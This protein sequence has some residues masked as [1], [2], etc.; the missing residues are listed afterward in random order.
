M[1]RSLTPRFQPRL[2]ALEERC[3]PSAA[4]RFLAP[5]ETDCVTAPLPAA[6]PPAFVPTAHLPANHAAGHSKSDVHAVPFKITGGGTAPLGLPVFPGGMAP[7]NATGTA[8]HLGK[9]TGDE[10]S[11]ELL[12]LD[13]ATL[14]GTFR[15]SFVFVAANGDRLAFDYGAD[16]DQPGTF[17]LT[18]TADGKVVAVFVAEFTPV[19]EESTGRFAKVTGGSFTM[20]ATS[21]A[22]ALTPN[23]Q[24]F[25]PPFAYTWAGEGSL[26]FGRG[27]K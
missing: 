16:P 2:E 13:P 18:P 9:Y 17:T 3:T 10:G 24:G 4:S 8:T 11:F 5:P 25:T 23:A 6:Q 15:G 19:P 22:F 14:T 7:H 27:K 20:V 26:E 1:K 21:E 12:S